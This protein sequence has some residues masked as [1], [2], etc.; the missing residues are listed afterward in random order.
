MK[1]FFII[2]VLV[3]Q[4]ICCQ[5]IFAQRGVGVKTK[6]G[7]E[8]ILYEN[9]YA[10]IIGNSNYKDGSWGNLPGVKA[11]VEAVSDILCQHGFKVEIAENL[12]SKTFDS[13]LKEFINKY[14]KTA[15]NRILIYYAGH[16]YKQK[17][18]GD[19]RDIGYVVPVDAPSP[20]KSDFN[21]YAVTMDTV[22][23]YAKEIQAKH[24]LF[25]F[26]NCFSGKL[27][28]RSPVIVPNEIN[29]KVGGA[30]RQFLTSGSSEQEVPDQSN[31]RRAFVRGLKGEA[32]ENGDGYTTAS[33]LAVFIKGVLYEEN[34]SPQYGKIND[35]NLNLG[36]FTFAKP[37]GKSN[38]AEKITE[39]TQQSESVKPTSGNNSPKIVE[40]NFFTFELNQC[41]LS[42]TVV[43]CDF[44]ITN[45]DTMDKKLGFEWDTNGRVFDE[46]GNQATM[47]N[48]VIANKS[49]NTILI[50]NVPV[51]ANFKFKNVSSNT[52]LLKRMDLAFVSYFS[53]G[54]YYKTRDFTV[55]FQ[56]ISLR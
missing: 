23:N 17:S 21:R 45:K 7:K 24:A 30:V 51:K 56:D 13:R 26:D 25:V 49:Y 28:S 34:Q 46:S 2:A 1:A 18:A 6:S 14:G 9:S 16:G 27:V 43:S 11:D 55:S 10:L 32:D 37:I 38:C 39:S 22:E 53:E 12:T 4:F 42:G 31:F 33:E 50:P 40:S 52:K 15:N 48:W 35:S 44:T 47:F 41:R 8:V 54:G 19:N 5:S 20:Q 29:E 3:F 36:D